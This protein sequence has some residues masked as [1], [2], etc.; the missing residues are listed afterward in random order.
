[1]RVKLKIH[2][3]IRLKR[4]QNIEFRSPRLNSLCSSSSKN[5]TGQ[6]GASEQKGW[7]ISESGESYHLRKIQIPY[8]SDITP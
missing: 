6:A 8:N 5:L 4:E 2:A 7:Q 1:M 3:S